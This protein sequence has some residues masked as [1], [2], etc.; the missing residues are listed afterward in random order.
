[1]RKF[2]ILLMSLLLLFFIIIPTNVNAENKDINFIGTVKQKYNFMVGDTLNSDDFIISGTISDGYNTWDVS[3]LNICVLPNKL[4]AI[5]NNIV[6]MQFKTKDSQYCFTKDIE[7][8]TVDFNPYMTCNVD[9]Q[10]IDIKDTVIY[11]DDG[12]DHIEYYKMLNFYT[13]NFYGKKISGYFNCSDNFYNPQLGYNKIDYTFIPFDSR[14]KSNNGTFVVYYNM[15]PK[16]TVSKTSIKINI[17]NS[18]KIYKIKVN[19]KWYTTTSINKLKSK[20]NY[21]VKIY[22]KPDDYLKE[23]TLLYSTTIKTK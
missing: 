14:Y 12:L 8:K 5:G 18:D 1:M 3:N 22:Q 2:K 13:F 7:V 15:T 16:I 11:S 23:N 17:D 21:T 9:K 6:S 20:T 10:Q 4:D 19:N